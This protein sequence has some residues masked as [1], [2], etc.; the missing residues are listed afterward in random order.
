MPWEVAVVLDSL[1]TLSSSKILAHNRQ[2]QCQSQLRYHR[3]DLSKMHVSKIVITPSFNPN[4]W[5]KSAHFQRQSDYL[6][7][8][9]G[10]FPGQRGEFVIIKE[11]CILSNPLLQKFFDRLTD[12]TSDMS[13]LKSIRSETICVPFW[14]S[15]FQHHDFHSFSTG[16]FSKRGTVSFLF[17]VR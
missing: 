9:R 12:Q 3:H 16:Q 13:Q 11:S 10:C 2:H 1:L 14:R 7:A 17:R 15:S 5:A 4:P 6:V 8:Y